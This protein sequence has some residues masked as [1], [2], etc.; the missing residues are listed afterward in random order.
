MK[1]LSLKQIL[2]FAGAIPAGESLVVNS[3]AITGQMKK[4]L[5]TSATLYRAGWLNQLV[6]GEMFQAKQVA[7]VGVTNFDRN[8]LTDGNYFLSDEVRF[9]FET[10]AGLEAGAGLTHA[11]WANNAPANFK[12]GEVVLSQ[13]KNLLE[14]SGTDITNFK[15][16]T[17]NDTDFKCLKSPFLIRPNAPFS[18][19]IALAYPATADQ[20]YKFEMRGVKIT[21]YSV[22]K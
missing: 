20:G 13:G 10:T 18:G 12:N 7:E 19:N 15:A 8:K 1:D 14:T 11:E 3:S 4:W 5:L 21:E 6:N 16:S 2:E 9:L 22:S 17:G